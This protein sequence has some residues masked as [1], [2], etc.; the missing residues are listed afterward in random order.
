MT[1]K[2]FLHSL[3]AGLGLCMAVAGSQAATISCTGANYD[4]ST[5]VGGASDCLI[6]SPLNGAVDDST[7]P[8]ASSYTVNT[9]SFFGIN[10]WA[11][12]GKYEV[13]NETNSSEFFSFSGDGQ[14]GGY[15]F[16]G[17]DNSIQFMFVMKDGI[18]TNLVAYLLSTPVPSGT[19]TYSTPF[20]NPPFPLTGKAAIRDISHIS[21]YY[22]SDAG[23]LGTGVPEPGTIAL[24]GLALLGMGLVFRQRKNGQV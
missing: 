7:S 24:L 14:S 11:F 22:V 2:T 17:A 5:S 9:E 6:F 10:T 23:G 16:S 13:T 8:P 15:G 3:L 12:D 4:I 20:T 18:G 1:T 21:V 19:N